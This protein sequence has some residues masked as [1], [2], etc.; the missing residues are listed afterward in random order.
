MSRTCESDSN[1]LV[2]C[3]DPKEPPTT[4]ISAD[5][6][7]LRA[8]SKRNL[9]REPAS[10]VS[11]R[12][13]IMAVLTRTLSGSTRGGIDSAPA[14]IPP[15]W[16]PLKMTCLES[17]ATSILKPIMPSAPAVASSSTSTISPGLTVRS[18]TP[19]SPVAGSR[20]STTCPC[21]VAVESA[22]TRPAI[23]ISR[24]ISYLRRSA[25]LV[26]TPPQMSGGL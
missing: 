23:P 5:P 18:R 9:P 14:I 24:F 1:F 17:K 26:V 7:R 11:L 3:P 12:P 2:P 15:A 21:A 10:S 4:L 16:N 22:S 8:A 25:K 20:S 6:P 19:W 13:P